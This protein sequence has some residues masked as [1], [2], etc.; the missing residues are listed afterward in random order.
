MNSQTKSVSYIWA[1]MPKV[2]K[3]ESLGS[4]LYDKE[5]TQSIYQV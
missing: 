5:N 2:Q 3:E 4:L 1:G